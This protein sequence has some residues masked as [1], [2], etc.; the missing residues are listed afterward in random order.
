LRY[1]RY[2]KT[3]LSLVLVFIGAKMLLDPHERP[4]RGIQVEIPISIS[5]L[6]VGGLIAASMVFSI[7]AARRDRKRGRP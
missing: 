4:P 2:L 3:G 5:L 1:F 6:V 7:L